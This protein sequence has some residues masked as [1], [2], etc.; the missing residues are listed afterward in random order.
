[1]FLFPV[2]ATF[3]AKNISVSLSHLT[4]I[5]EKTA[6]AA[7][8]YADFFMSN[9]TLICNESCVFN[10]QSTSG[11]RSR[12]KLVEVTSSAGPVNLNFVES[13]ASSR[14][15]Y[16]VDLV[17]TDCAFADSLHVEGSKTAN[18]NA[19]VDV[20][21]L[22]SSF[23]RGLV[24]RSIDL[25]S[26]RMS[27]CV[28]SG[29]VN[30]S[31]HDEFN[32]VAQLVISQNSFLNG[33]GLDLPDAIRINTTLRFNS[34][35]KSSAVGSPGYARPN[36]LA[37]VNQ[38]HVDARANWWDSTLGPYSCCNYDSDGVYAVLADTSSWCLDPTCANISGRISDV[39]TPYEARFCDL[40]TL[41][42][43]GVSVSLVVAGS[44]VAFGSVACLSL[45]VWAFWSD[46]TRKQRLAN[47]EF[48]EQVQ[49]V[50]RSSHRFHP[51][52]KT[53]HVIF[54]CV[55]IV[56]DLCIGL[57]AW[58]PI[59]FAPP[60]QKTVDTEE[61]MPWAVLSSSVMCA[62]SVIRACTSCWTLFIL[63][64]PPGYKSLSANT[65]VTACAALIAVMWRMSA[66]LNGYHA[67]EASGGGKDFYVVFHGSEL[68]IHTL[69][70]WVLWIYQAFAQVCLSVPIVVM[71]LRILTKRDYAE[72][73]LHRRFRLLVSCHLFMPTPVE[74]MK[75][76]VE[77]MPGV[78]KKAF[79]RTGRLD[80]KASILSAICLAFG[81][82][83]FALLI[84]FA[85][86]YQVLALGAAPI[87]MFAVVL[88][89]C[90]AI[91]LQG[92]VTLR[93]FFYDLARGWVFFALMLALSINWLELCGY[94]FFLLAD[95]GPTRIKTTYGVIGGTGL[96][97]FLAC[98]A[99]ATY[100]FRLL[101]TMKHELAP[102]VAAAVYE[103]LEEAFG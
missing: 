80:R 93:W 12:V 91:S 48:L 45:A 30:L 10:L 66:T 59:L 67:T 57:S 102:S 16:T 21:L 42:S 87:Y 61:I 40:E 22:H 79:M 6:L 17:I 43:P 19:T 37:G 23:A 8:D 103:R 36:V 32:G 54:L 18:P 31:P 55:S 68:T 85:S 44:I 86:V 53:L 25:A 52:G 34:F 15:A 74:V 92:F 62:V 58:T 47:Q 69:F 81:T 51:E 26:L 35:Y 20:A 77:N 88:I 56:V 41:C 28:I 100:T 3:T 98:V 96:I 63:R 70:Y 60:A 14:G 84:V 65:I 2:S 9:V 39:W 78:P 99:L 83:L 94:Y 72:S 4:W 95:A 46:R 75:K 73:T 71:G 13:D 24:Y 5:P 101:R 1:L 82:L 97:L 64:N 33:S 50:Q 29:R 89:V 90:G 7:A 27:Y 38:G 76:A 49:L 11:S